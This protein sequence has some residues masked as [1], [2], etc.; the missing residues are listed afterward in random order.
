MSL[1]G[2]GERRVQALIPSLDNLG[3][4]LL[5][6]EGRGLHVETARSALTVILKLVISGLTTIILI[7][8]CSV[9]QLW[10]TLC[11]PIDC[12]LPGSSFHGIFQA[13]ILEWVA[14]TSSRGAS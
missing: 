13:R 4:E 11:D 10:P 6:T 5:L 12:S 8:L 1:D 9:A 3:Q 14:M 2:I 7:A